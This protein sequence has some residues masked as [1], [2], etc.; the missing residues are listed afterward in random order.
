MTENARNI[1][2][3]VLLL[4]IT[5]SAYAI[6]RIMKKTEIPGDPAESFKELLKSPLHW[7]CLIL[8]IAALVV[9][10]YVHGVFGT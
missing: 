7:V 9:A 8:I 3:I 6:T 4:I 10:G 5:G 2:D 1:I